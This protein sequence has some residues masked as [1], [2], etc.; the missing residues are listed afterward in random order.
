MLRNYLIEEKIVALDVSN[1]CST[2][3][4]IEY[5][6]LS[7]SNLNLMRSGPLKLIKDTGMQGRTREEKRRASRMKVKV[8]LP[9]LNRILQ[10]VKFQFHLNVQITLFAS[11]QPQRTT[12]ACN[13]S[14][15]PRCAMW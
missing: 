8:G 9:H 5:I 13:P 6:S 4:Y 12:L 3:I 11:K 7:E 14:Y 10:G 1:Y 15:Y 2:K